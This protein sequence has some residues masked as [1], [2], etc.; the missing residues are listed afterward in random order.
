MPKKETKERIPMITKTRL[1]SE[2]GWTDKLLKIFLPEPD[3]K[4]PNP[5]YRSAAPMLL[6]DLDKVKTI[7]K[8]EERSKKPKNFKLSKRKL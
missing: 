3:L 2:R 4:R 5:N 7:E 8:T 1:K 6:F